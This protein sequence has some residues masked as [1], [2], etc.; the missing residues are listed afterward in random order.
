[1]ARTKNQR[2]SSGE[3]CKMGLGVMR[4]CASEQISH[5]PFFF[6][7]MAEIHVASDNSITTILKQNSIVSR[8]DQFRSL[9]LASAENADSV[10]HRLA[11]TFLS[12]LSLAYILPHGLSTSCVDLLLVIPTHQVSLPGCLPLLYLINSSSFFRSQI[13]SEAFPGLPL[14]T[15][16]FL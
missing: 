2:F 5:K 8:L 10:S 15:Q 13:L 3:V 9:S 12:S 6:S 11:L 16:T 14:L 7:L 4:T 1:M